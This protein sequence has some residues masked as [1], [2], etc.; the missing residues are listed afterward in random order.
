MYLL[1]KG[2]ERGT[3]TTLLHTPAVC[4]A[5]DNYCQRKFCFLIAY[6]HTIYNKFKE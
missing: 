4:G 1:P 5:E 2:R 6:L 3:V